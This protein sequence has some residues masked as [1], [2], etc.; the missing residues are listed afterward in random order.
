M[1]SLLSLFLYVVY[2]VGM[3]G[4]CLRIWCELGSRC[5]L[6]TDID[7]MEHDVAN[8]EAVITLK[9]TRRCIR[10]TFILRLSG[11]ALYKL[12]LVSRRNDAITYQYQENILFDAGEYFLDAAVLLCQEF[13]TNNMTEICIESPH[14][15]RNV[16]NE[17]YSLNVAATQ[18]GGRTAGLPR[19]MPTRYQKLA[20]A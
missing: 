2:D 3:Y 19:I 12:G 7:S 16:I 18:H 8:R 10:P 20:E 13:D 14:Y 11:A 17:P 6:C 1:I 4:V 9:E 5:T 15:Q